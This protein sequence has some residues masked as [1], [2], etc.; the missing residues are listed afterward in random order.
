MASPLRYRLPG[1]PA[2][3][4]RL[5]AARAPRGRRV[6]YAGAAGLLVVGLGLL[7]SLVEELAAPMGPGSHHDFLAFWSA[8]RLVLEGRQGALYEPAALTA[9]QREVIPAPIGANGYMPFINPPFAA[10]AFAPLAALP[11]EVARAAW[12]GM[13]LVLLLGAGSWLAR[14]LPLPLRI[15]AAALVALSAPA[16]LSLAEGQWSAVLLVGGEAAL[17]AARRGSWRLAGLALATWWLKPQLL[18]L[19]ILALALGRRWT[20]IGW[21][22]LGGLVHIVVGLPFTGIDTYGSYAAYLLQVGVSHF[23]GAG[24]LAPSTWQGSLASTEGLN[25]L[26]VGVF[27]QGQVG[28]VNAI[29]VVLSVALVGLWLVAAA[30][31]RPGFD[32]PGGRR[33]LAAGVGVLLLTNPNLFA[34]DCVLVFLALPV[35]VP[36]ESNALDRWAASVVVAGLAALVLIDQATGLHVFTIALLVLTTA[37][38]LGAVAAAPGA[39]PLAG[40]RRDATT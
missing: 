7:V 24:A 31:Q 17:W 34:Q 33:V 14:P 27:G 13:S 28:V 23:D 1:R 9:I 21:A 6:L 35:V 32:S 5:R 16:I 12:A 11:V 38:C 29:W 8:G 20:P 36:A 2:L 39:G 19:P 40:L 10:V 22:L 30:A 25:G 18:V 3:S 15:A 4:T 26:L 37:G